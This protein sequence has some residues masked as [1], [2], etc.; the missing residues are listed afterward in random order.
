MM[1]WQPRTGHQDGV[2]TAYASNNLNQYTTVGDVSY[3]Y[4]T[5]GNLNPQAIRIGRHDLQLQPP[6]TGSSPSPTDRNPSP[7]LTMPSAMTV[8]ST[9]KGV[10]TATVRDQLGAAGNVVGEYGAGRCPH[11][12]TV[13]AWSDLQ[14][15][16]PASRLTTTSP[17][18]ARRVSSQMQTVSL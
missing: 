16:Q 6:R 18:S 13:I 15:T 3:T 8:A 14:S 9:N 5:D 10:I 1:R 11:S 7:T 12:H 17:P 2:T 4:D